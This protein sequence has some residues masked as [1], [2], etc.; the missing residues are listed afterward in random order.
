MLINLLSYSL[1]SVI[2]EAAPFAN[3]PP[4]LG[5]PLKLSGMGDD[6]DKTLSKKKNDWNYYPFHCNARGVYQLHKVS[7]VKIPFFS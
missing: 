6:I 7:K 3:A 5:A 4:S 1:L 2:N